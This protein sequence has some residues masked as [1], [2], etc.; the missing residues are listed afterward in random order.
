MK[1]LGKFLLFILGL[2]LIALIAV[3]FSLGLIVKKA[4]TSVVP[5][6]TKTTATIDNVD[7]S[8]FSGRIA[9]S[10]FSIGNPAGFSDHNAF[11]IKNVLIEFEPKSILTNTIVVNKVSVDGTEITAELNQK[12]EINLNTLYQNINSYINQGSTP[13][14]KA[15]AQST[16]TNTQKEDG[17]GVAL[18]QLSVADS[19][20]NLVVLKQSQ[21]IPLPNINYVDKGERRSIPQTIALIMNKITKESLA[22]IQKSGQELINK[23][24]KN[25]ENAAKEAAQKQLGEIK[26]QAAESLSESVGGLKNLFK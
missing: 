7:L 15:P 8:L 18:K 10:D 20:I 26:N 24:L 2:L 6:V 9:F 11:Q 14:T 25:L 21:R 13:T 17:K 5:S 22:G 4:V 3:Y 12:G 16:T 1:K 19:A 23:Q